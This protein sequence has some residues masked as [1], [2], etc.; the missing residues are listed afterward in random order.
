MSS[1]K[2][3]SAVLCLLGLALPATAGKPNDNRSPNNDSRSDDTAQQPN[4]GYTKE[5][6]GKTLEEW[7]KDL[8]ALDPSVRAAALMRI[9]YFKQA[10]EVVPDVAAVLI[11]DGDASPRV[12]AAIALRWIPHR[13]ADRTRVIRSLGRAISHDPQSI[14]RYEAAATLMTLCPLHLD[15]KEERDAIMDLV[16]GLNSTST[17]EL[18]DICITTLIKAGVDP[19]SGPDT[20]VTDALI[21]LANH[22]M[23]PTTQVRLNAIMALGAMG[24]P[25]NP[26]KLKSV[27]AI[28]KS[29]ANYGSSHLT[30]RIWSH[31]A[32]IALEEKV[33]EKDLQTIANYL[34]H[35]EA[36]IRVQA[37][38][39]LGA[40]G[41]KAHAYVGKVCDML[42][43]EKDIFVRVAG[44]LALGRM[45]NKGDRVLSTLIHM[46]EDDERENVSVVLQA[47]DALL[48]LDANDAASLQA[49]DK[50]LEHKSLEKYQKDIVQRIIKEI[51]NPKKK[52]D[53]AKKLDKTTGRKGGGR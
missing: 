27:L 26:E 33:N 47:C 7:K 35:R 3:L 39:A 11:K 43:R 20:R 18:R 38:S 21:R 8:I 36:A 6:G 32:I 24:R 44:A 34:T 42:Q 30:I 29:K 12:K 23:E 37:V 9:P 51:K 5:V 19:K 45:K 31:V 10:A 40:L 4:Y 48:Q 1:S 17:F 46:S 16:A 14:I 49:L 50:V 25:Q 52:P 41:D 2:L 28:L 15:V 22:M 13:D 53:V